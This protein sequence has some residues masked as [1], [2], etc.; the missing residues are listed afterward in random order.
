MTPPDRPIKLYTIPFKIE[1]HKIKKPFVC[2]AHS[3]GEA[4]AMA[5]RCIP[6]WIT[7]RG[8]VVGSLTKELLQ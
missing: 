4:Y 1:G 7:A 8:W 5:A 2:Y 3:P 6:H